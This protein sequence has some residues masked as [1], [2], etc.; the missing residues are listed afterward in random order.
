MADAPKLTTE[1]LLYEGVPKINAAIDNAN[2]A[3]KVASTG[4]ISEERFVDSVYV[5]LSKNQSLQQLQTGVTNLV[6]GFD[7]SKTIEEIS[8]YRDEYVSFPSIGST[9][10]ITAK[11]MFQIRAD[12]NQAFFFRKF[13]CVSD[14]APGKKVSFAVKVLVDNGE[15]KKNY[16]FLDSSNGQIGGIIPLENIGDGWYIAQDITVPTNAIT[17]EF[18]MDYRTGI[19]GTSVTYTEETVMPGSYLNKADMKMKK[20]LAEVQTKANDAF[21]KAGSG[22]IFSDPLIKGIEWGTNLSSASVGFGKREVINGKGLFVLQNVTIAYKEAFYTDLKLSDYPTILPGDTVRFENNIYDQTVNGLRRGDNL[23]LIIA[24]DANNVELGRKATPNITSTG[25]YS[26]DL[27]IPANTSK[28]RLRWDLQVDT[29]EQMANVYYKIDYISL[30]KVR[31]GGHSQLLVPDMYTTRAMIDKAVGDASTGA[32]FHVATTGDDMKDGK[33]EGTAFATFSKAI[34][35]GATTIIAERGD[36]YNVSLSAT[37]LKEITILPRDHANFDQSKPDGKMIN[38]Y[39]GEKLSSSSWVPYNAIYKQ[40][41]VDNTYY[42]DVFVNKT[43]P[44]D[45]GGTRPSYN[46]F[47]WEDNNKLV[48]KLTIA[49]VEVT[50]GSFTYDGKNVYMNP[51]VGSTPMTSRIYVAVTKGNVVDV[52]KTKKVVLHDVEAKFCQGTPIIAKNVTDLKVQNCAANYGGQGNGWTLDNSN[53]LLVD[54]EGAWNR[55]DGFNIHGYG[56]TVY[57]NCSGH[58]NEDDGISHHDG[59]TGYIYGGEWYNNGKGG[60]IP[61]YGA[62][63]H[64]ENAVCYNN[65][66][67]IFYGGTK[68][69]TP[70]RSV[71]VSNVLCYGNKRAGLHVS[72]EYDVKA[73]NVVLRNNQVGAQI[74]SNGTLEIENSPIT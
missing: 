61:T 16:R 6:Y 37:N 2:E 3:L 30:S 18:R 31:D 9:V 45:T 28:L 50:P 14:L 29:P 58:D 60:I 19:T 15:L 36:Y 25:L 51:Y 47:L 21:S 53:G 32:T 38:L 48:P 64:T 59:C 13:N 68:G 56:D 71:H 11:K 22:N 70:K 52:S 65:V 73:Y 49:E 40:P 74:E 42:T 23:M 5:K 43:L 54:C 7:G 12:A 62:I 17:L 67:G 46:A 69:L 35:A 39:G 44:I 10:S 57:I 34:A 66:F 4:P 24:Y 8:A 33:T 41:Y 1:D 27:L 63:V 20:D 26:A 72:H 55:N